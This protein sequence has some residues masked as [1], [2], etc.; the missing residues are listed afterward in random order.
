[1][2]R[3]SARSLALFQAMFYPNGTSP[4]STPAWTARPSST[5]SSPPSGPRIAFKERYEGKFAAMPGAELA[6]AMAEYQRIEEIQGRLVSFASLMFSGDGTDPKLGQ[7]YQSVTERVT[8]LSSNLIFFTLELNRLDEAV[9]DD[10]LSDP[11][12]MRW[13]PWLRDLRVFRPHQLSDEVEKLLHE[14]E[15]HRPQRVE[16]GCSTRPSLACASRSVTSS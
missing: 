6:E 8:A 3:S 2:A 5:T 14:K 13:G 15:G 1:M 9:L 12:L 16:A 10:K 7:F 4:T 11:A